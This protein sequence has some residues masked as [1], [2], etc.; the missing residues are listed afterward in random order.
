MRQTHASCY[1]YTSP[2]EQYEISTFRLASFTFVTSQSHTDG[3]DT[4]CKVGHGNE[5]SVGKDTFSDEQVYLYVHGASQAM[6]PVKENQNHKTMLVILWAL[7]AFFNSIFELFTSQ[8]A[9]SNL[10]MKM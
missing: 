2:I 4:R 9:R 10:D 6:S 7:N 8:W 1:E 3:T 5:I